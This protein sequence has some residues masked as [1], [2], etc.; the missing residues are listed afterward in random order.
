MTTANSKKPIVIVCVAVVLLVTVAMLLACQVWFSKQT[1][2]QDVTVELGTDS[3]G[4]SQ[5]MTEYALP[6]RVS[7]ISDV[8]TMRGEVLDSFSDGERMILNAR[9]PVQTSLDYSITLASF[10]G[11][12]GA[13]SVRL[14]GYRE[15]PLE[16]GAT[17]KRR[18][19][20]PLDTSK[21]ILAA[22]SALEGGIFDM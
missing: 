11:G 18:N 22:R 12:R 17:A 10:T 6:H 3:L 21:Y 13:M 15:C 7:F 8:S 1:K 14:H 19:V 20:D 16:L 9:I 2:F 4:I 5:F